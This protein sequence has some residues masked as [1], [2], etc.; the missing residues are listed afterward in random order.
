[1]KKVSAISYL[2]D[3]AN[4]TLHIHYI[5]PYD[6]NLFLTSFALLAPT[7]GQ[8]D[9]SLESTNPSHPVAISVSLVVV[10]VV[11]MVVV[12][13]LIRKR[14]VIRSVLDR[15]RVSIQK[16]VTCIHMC[17]LQSRTPLPTHS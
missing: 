13:V 14:K 15:C 9:D 1:M 8:S 5:L 4:M 3:R 11:V 10:A 17:T 16:N 6:F 7:L 2:L 12:G